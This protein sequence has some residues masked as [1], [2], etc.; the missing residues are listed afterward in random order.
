MSD[1]P[2]R[3][4]ASSR[5][6]RPLVQVDRLSKLYPLRRGLLSKP[7]ILHAVDNASFYI[8]RGETLGLVGESGCGKTT[9]GRAILR[10]VEPTA[11]RIHFDGKDITQMPEK[12]L[13]PLRRRM[14][15]VFQDPYSSLNPHMTVREIVGE[16]IS[17]F[18][19]ARTRS[20][21][22]VMIADVLAKVGLRPD[23]MG[24]Y[25]HEFSGGQRQ[26]LGIARALAVRPDFIVCDEPISALDVSVQA[27]ILNLLEELQEELSVS[28]LFISH[29]L[30]A[31]AYL[32]HRVAV[33]YRGRIVE[34]GP[35]ADVRTKRYHPYTRALWSAMPG[36]P[37]ADLEVA[38]AADEGAPTS[39][40][41]GEARRSRPLPIAGQESETAG[42]PP[43]GC[44]F[45][46]RCPKA[47]K[48]KCDVEVPVLQEIVPNS[49]HR[50]A[51]FFPEKD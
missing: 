2:V 21:A 45:H 5:A 24:R 49:H 30:R 16:G 8:R 1:E 33:M 11:G 42:D 47:E 29:D 32:S 18:R 10:L 27:Q 31:V 51:C 39:E 7:A 44:V 48:G 17:V 20:E 6:S 37:S 14:Q 9:L 25:P 22:D 46:P 40:S 35:T 23:I 4:A 38:V 12:E 3:S 36:S 50:A 13:R 41:K 19:L 34:M 26:R 43:R 28:L 15:I